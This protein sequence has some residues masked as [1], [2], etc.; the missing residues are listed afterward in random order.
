MQLDRRDF[1][2]AAAMAAASSV[3]AGGVPAAALHSARGPREIL[4][5]SPGESLRVGLVGGRLGRG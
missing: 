2:R 1:V 5:A 3:A 4:K